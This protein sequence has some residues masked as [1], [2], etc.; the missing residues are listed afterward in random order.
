MFVTRRALAGNRGPLT[1][2]LR[3]QMR[4]DVEVHRQDL[5][6]LL[7][8]RYDL[9][10]CAAPGVPPDRRSEVDPEQDHRE[11]V[12][13]AR[14]LSH[15]RTRHLVVLSTVAVYGGLDVADETTDVDAA[16]GESWA[17]H[18]YWFEQKLRE[19]HPSVVVLRVPLVVG[20][21][22]QGPS[23]FL[24]LERGSMPTGLPLDAALQCYDVARL[25]SDLDRAVSAGLPLANLVGEPVPASELARVC[26]GTDVAAA[27]LERVG[28]GRDG[29][30][31]T[32]TV[33]DVR[34]VHA[35]VFG[36]T[37][38]YV[39]DRAD[40]IDAVARWAR[41]RSPAAAVGGA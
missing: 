36:G 22:L 28:D 2:S 13:L 3:A 34:T 4:F 1:A 27:P 9:I 16:A 23:E 39:M 35:D 18:R 32:V 6:T 12:Q 7:D 10:V 17:R 29:R 37:G 33:P 26:F 20:P 11:L 14:V 30:A 38:S 21:W 40:T 25:A 5:T 19:H 31:S 24:E 15:V 41:R 8:D